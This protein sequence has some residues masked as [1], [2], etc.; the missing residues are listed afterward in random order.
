MSE[1]AT[2]EVQSTAIKNTRLLLVRDSGHGSTVSPV[3]NVPR[4][5]MY[6]SSSCPAALYQ[7]ACGQSCDGVERLAR[8]PFMAA[9]EF[10]AE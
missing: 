10:A 2:G 8:S 5:H 6:S 4:I 9:S 3:R 7:I 1:T